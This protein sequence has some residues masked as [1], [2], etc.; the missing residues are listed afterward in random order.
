[1]PDCY[2]GSP[3]GGEQIH[4]FQDMVAGQGQQSEDDFGIFAGGELLEKH[5]VN[6]PEKQIILSGKMIFI[7][8]AGEYLNLRCYLSAVPGQDF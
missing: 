8:C 1:M 7:T 2:G 5:S 3:K 4:Q 6:C